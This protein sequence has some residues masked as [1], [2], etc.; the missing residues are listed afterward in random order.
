VTIAS[1]T[2]QRLV[3]FAGCK[4]MQSVGLYNKQLLLTSRIELP[5][6]MQSTARSVCQH[7]IIKHEEIASNIAHAILREL[8]HKQSIEILLY[9]I[10][11]FSFCSRSQ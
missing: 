9:F 10:D 11:F 5:C 6:D 7:Y 8:S 3:R 4:T 2:Q 1:D